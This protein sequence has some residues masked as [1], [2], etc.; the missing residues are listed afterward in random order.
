MTGVRRIFGAA[1]ALPAG[2]YSLVRAAITLE[3]A[4]WSSLADR[5]DPL[6]T[7]LLNSP[8]AQYL[9]GKLLRSA[10]RPQEAIAACRISLELA[11]GDPAALLELGRSL[12]QA[13]ARHDAV[14]A[15]REAAMRGSKAARRELCRYSA[16]TALP[17]REPGVFAREDYAAFVAGNPVPPP[18]SSSSPVAVFAI[19]LAGDAQAATMESLARQSC[20]TWLLAG[21]TVPQGLEDLPVYELT[22]QEGAVLDRECLAWLAHAAASG[23]SGIVRAD[24]DHFDPVTTLR[25]EPVFL[26]HPDFLWTEGEG[27]IV[28]LEAVCRDLPAKIVQVPLVLMSL[29]AQPSGQA[30]QPAPDADPRPV[31]VIIPTRDN[32]ALLEVAVSS[33]LDAADRPDNV[34]IIIVDNGSRAPETHALFNRLGAEARARIVRF[35]EP[36]NWSRANNVGAA[37][38]R[39]ETLLFLNDDTVMQTTGWDRILAGV[40]SNPA[41]GVVGAR[42]VYPDDTIQHGGFVFGMDNGPQHEGRWMPATDSG[43][44]GRWTATRQAVAVTGAFLAV[45]AVDFAALGGFDEKTFRIDFADV[46]FCLRMRAEGKAVAYCG[47]ITLVHHESVSR[48]LNLG[49]AKR[50]RMSEEWA[51]FKERWGAAVE[52]DPGYHPV[53]CRTGAAYDGLAASNLVDAAKALPEA[54]AQWRIGQE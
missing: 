20:S 19:T 34:Q 31:S 28:A 21:G 14:C 9:R 25:C 2:L 42:M 7:V 13:G 22:L 12:R 32:P 50:K 38:T 4:D 18:P 24:H 35:D 49:R 11:P 54:Q 17:E 33:L 5:L 30:G 48:G 44:G 16:R 27:R 53:W 10:R 8:R 26:P 40:L 29:P 51:R 37:D 47:A 43:P 52:R 6:F 3:P 41:V 39:T 15:L 1:M 46:D 23:Q 36:F 45:R